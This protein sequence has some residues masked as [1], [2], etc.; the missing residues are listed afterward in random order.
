MT[1]IHLKKGREESLLRRHPWLFSGAISRIEG[2]PYEGDIVSIISQSG[3]CLGYGHFQIGSIAVRV[4]SFD[5]AALSPDFWKERIGAAYRHR[6]S[7]SLKNTNCYRLVHGEGDM[8]PGLV[9]DWYNG[10]A[11][12]QAHS[13]GMFLSLDKISDAL[14]EV[15]GK[16]LKAVYD[17]SSGTAP[18]NAGLDLNDGFLY[19]NKDFADERE[20]IVTENGHKFIVNWEEGQKTGFFLDQRE[21]RSLVERYAAGRNVLNLFSYTGGFSIYALAG[22][23]ISVD[24][25]DS[26]AKAVAMM[27]RNVALNAFPNH[28]SFCEDAID[29]VKNSPFGK[30]DM[31]IVDPPAFAKHRGAI[32]NALRGYQRLNAAAISK[33]APGGII[34]TFSCSQV[35]DS[36]S[37]ALTIFSAAAETGR[38]VKILDRLNQPADHPVN[39][40]HPEGEYLKGLI[41][42]VE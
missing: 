15:Y 39:I 2:E 16:E 35:V 27:E 1:R 6:L 42:Y 3:E 13:V 38:N 17:K 36:N 12:V 21:N 23:A 7:L 28:H 20:G 18:F 5:D 37:F 9:V 22:G 26:S 29:F 34:F 19:R 40:F 41:L 33:V 4:L 30:Y 25:V 14:R 24:S 11:V 8:L 10:V 31:M 32:R